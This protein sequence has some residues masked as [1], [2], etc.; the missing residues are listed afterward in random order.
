MKKRDFPP[1][2]QPFLKVFEQLTYRHEIYQVFQDYV[3]VCLNFMGNGNFTEERDNRMKNYK[4]EEHALFNQCFEEMVKLLDR[5]IVGPNDWYDCFGEFYQAITSSWKASAMGQFFTPDS[6]VNFM[7][8]IIHIERNESK[9]H[10][11]ASEPAAGSGR[12]IIAQHAQNPM[13]FYWAVDLDPLCAQMTAVNMALHNA[14]GVVLHANGLWEDKEFFRAY[15]VARVEVSENVFIPCIYPVATYEEAREIMNKYHQYAH[16]HNLAYHFKEYT[17]KQPADP[18]SETAVVEI[19][20]ASEEL[21]GEVN[22][23]IIEVAIDQVK[24]KNKNKKHDQL[25]LF[26]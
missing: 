22:E 11:T 5:K 15:H 24:T 23:K 17:G 19:L 7:V 6:V 16:I 9:M 3:L 2:L 4:P 26:D 18:I 8:K 13:G 20:K 14:V 10:Y 12:F 25:S 21:K 1:D